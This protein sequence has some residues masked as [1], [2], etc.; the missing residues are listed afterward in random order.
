MCL[1]AGSHGFV[2]T[3][4]GCNGRFDGVMEVWQGIDAY[5]QRVDQA[6]CSPDCK[7]NIDT[8]TK[9][10]YETNPTLKSFY[11]NWNTTTTEKFGATSFTNCTIQVRENAKNLAEQD[12]KLFNSRKDFKSDLFARY[13]GELE[14][15]F[16]CAG[17]CN[18]TYVDPRLKKSTTMYKYLFSNINE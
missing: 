4:F 8:K 9:V 12:D 3:Y 6:L 16:K 5:L 13:M 17:W 15:T 14:H 18:V 2:N 11:Q 10:K 7:C 1:I